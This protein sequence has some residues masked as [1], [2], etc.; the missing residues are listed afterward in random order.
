M[1]MDAHLTLILGYVMFCTLL[2]DLLEKI[3][4]ADIASD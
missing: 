4:E 3:N 2:F 1:V